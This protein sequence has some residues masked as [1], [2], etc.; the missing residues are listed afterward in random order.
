MHQVAKDDHGNAQATSTQ[1]TR[2]PAAP[3][4]QGKKLNIKS[5]VDIA[6]TVGRAVLLIV[7]L[8]RDHHA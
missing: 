3:D 1:G 7:E 8:V 6:T 4:K 5:W 2:P